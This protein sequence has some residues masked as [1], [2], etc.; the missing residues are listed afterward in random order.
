[1]SSQIVQ[2][3]LNPGRLPGAKKISP[4]GKRFE[5]LIYKDGFWATLMLLPNLAGFTMFLLVPVIAAFILSF[6]EFDVIS[7]M[8]FIGLDNYVEMIKDPIVHQTLLNTLIYTVITVPV[9]M[10]LSLILSV[11]LDQKIMARRI[12]RAVYFLPSIT[13]MVAV[14]VVW[15]WI[16]N[17]EFG[18]LNYVLSVFNIDGLNWLSSSKTSLISLAIVGVWKSM[19]YN[20]LLF[21]AGLQGISNSYY[22]AAKL[23]GA[24]P[25]QEFFYITLPLLRPTTFFIFIMAIIGSFQVFDSV[26]LMTQGG[27]GRS[28]S[29]LVHYLYQNAF[30]YF[31][32][33]YA[34]ALAYLLFF[35][36]FILTLIN[37]KMEKSSSAYS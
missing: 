25:A 3:D 27:P 8:K 31:R 2:S 20:M 5:K 30:Q 9:G 34:C 18:L 7:P 15:Q 17:P 32:M 10:L 13:S 35:I 28:S 33:G 36:V 23:D 12:Y 16:Y 14:A 22:E 21:L 1:M 24:S 26:M 19:G 6:T 4:K 11:A 37:L 29:V